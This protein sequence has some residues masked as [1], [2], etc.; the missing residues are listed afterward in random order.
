MRLIGFSTGAI[1]KGDCRLALELMKP[2]GLPVVEL[3]ALRLHELPRLT[4]EA[5]SLDLAGYR[6]ISVHAPSHF[7][8]EDERN[9]VT[10]LERL[11]ARGWVIVVHPDAIFTD[12]LWTQFGG[13]LLIE[14]SDKRKSLGRTAGELGALFDRFRDARF[15][16][17]VGHARQ[18]DPTMNE[19]YLILQQTRD[20]LCQIHISEVN[21]FSRHDPLSAAAVEASRRIAH[22]IP[23]DVPIILETLIDQGQSTIEAEV[24]RASQALSVTLPVA[25]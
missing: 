1:A 25:V 5:G 19:A 20:R 22:L 9:V 8:P 2:F 7:Q 11:A 6:Y 23:E 15:C 21:C 24:R 13:K 10:L 3:S 14:N 16:F 4:E 18:V 17:D 12:A